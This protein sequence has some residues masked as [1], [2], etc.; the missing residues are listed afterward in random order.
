VI[1]SGQNQCLR[2]VAVLA[3]NNA[4]WADYAAYC[5]DRERGLRRQAFRHLDRFLATARSWSFEVRK[6]FVN[7]LC[8]QLADYRETDGY[9][10]IPQPLIDRLV[11]STL[12]E[13]ANKESTDASPHRWMGLFFARAA[14]SAM[15]AGLWQSPRDAYS[16]LRAALDR[17]PNDQLARIR[18]IEMLIGDAEYSCH[19]LPDIYIG[20][21]T[22]DATRLA[23]ATEHLVY[24]CD[25]GQ[26]ARLQSELGHVSQLIEDWVS[27]KNADE[28]DFNQWCSDRGRQYQWVRAYYYTPRREK[29]SDA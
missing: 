8:L 11:I 27:F 22:A 21:P 23:E 20:D 18:I 2:D 19:H 24:V 12:D 14:Y 5:T 10:L 29:E 3:L 25:P 6:E 1:S 15:R 26:K 9:G 4:A 7:W 13:W 28:S 17:D 16:H